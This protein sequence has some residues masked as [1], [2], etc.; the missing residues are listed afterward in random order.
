MLVFLLK[1]VVQAEWAKMGLK[2]GSFRTQTSLIPHCW[3]PTPLAEP[4]PLSP[5]PSCIQTPTTSAIHA[6]GA[7]MCE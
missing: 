7:A 6:T 1:L 2:R 5:V 3:R 4:V